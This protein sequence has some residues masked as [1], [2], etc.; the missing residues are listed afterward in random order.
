MNRF[1]FEEQNFLSHILNQIVDIM[2]KYDDGMYYDN[3]SINLI[4]NEN[5]MQCIKD[6]LVEL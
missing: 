1:T 6:M 3:G 4:L 2:E 5:E